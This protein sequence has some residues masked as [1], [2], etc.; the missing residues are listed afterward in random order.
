[1]L[2]NNSLGFNFEK[3]VNVDIF[4][5]ASA[6]FGEPAELWT[7]FNYW[8]LEHFDKN[9]LFNNESLQLVE[10]NLIDF[11]VF[12]VRRT[13][14]AEFVDERRNLRAQNIFVQ[15]FDANVSQNVAVV[16]ELNRAF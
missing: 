6:T 5:E 11:T 14:K 1:M 15:T 9:L 7:S 8:L 2:L 10:Q 4:L 16:D 12:V 13:F 3:A